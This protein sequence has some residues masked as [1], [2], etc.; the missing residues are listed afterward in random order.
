MSQLSPAA[1]LNGRQTG[2]ICDRCNKRVRTGDMVQVY[3]TWY[4]DETGTTD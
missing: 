3:A 2:R 1:T 4:D